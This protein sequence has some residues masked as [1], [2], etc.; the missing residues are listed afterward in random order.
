MSDLIA[1]R[2]RVVNRAVP[3]KLCQKIV[4]KYEKEYGFKT[5]NYNGDLDLK[6]RDSSEVKIEDRKVIKKVW[7]HIK[8]YIP[9]TCDSKTLVGPH[10][11]RVYLLKYCEEQFFKPHYDGYSTDSKGN[12]SHITVLIYL[13]TLTEEGGGGTR[14]YEE[15]ERNIYFKGNNRD[16]KHVTLYPEIGTMVMFTHRL[17]HEGTPLKHGYKYCLRLNVLYGN[18]DKSKSTS[19]PGKVLNKYIP[20]QMITHK[21]KTIILDT[22]PHNKPAIDRWVDVMLRPHVFEMEILENPFVDNGRGR[23]PGWDEDFC[24]NC[25]EILDINEENLTKCYN[26]QSKVININKERQKIN[27][28]LHKNKEK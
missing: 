20:K 11:R 18:L 27:L 13:N 12:K 5:C 4:D 19:V 22:D 7:K 25:H 28:S 17:L 14:F 26:C 6:Y 24:P 16:K 23:P 9:D 10:Y 1:N 3:E 15:P 21:G 2:L 8:D